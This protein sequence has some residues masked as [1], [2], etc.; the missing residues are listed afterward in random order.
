[1]YIHL[2][3]INFASTLFDSNDISTIRGGSM[4]NDLL[5]QALSNKLSAE[6][7]Q[8]GGSKLLARLADSE[9]PRVEAQLQEV[10]S[11]PDFKHLSVTWGFGETPQD[12]KSESQWRAAQL[13]SVPPVDNTAASA[14]CPLDRTRAAT[15]DEVGPDGTHRKVSS[16][17]AARREIAR[18]KRPGLFDAAEFGPARSLADIAVLP[19]HKCSVPPVVR[20]KIAVICA[21]G[22]GGSALGASLG[23]AQMSQ[24]MTAFRQRLAAAL[25]SWAVEQGLVYGAEGDMRARMDVFF[26]GGD[27]MRFVV[28]AH[29]A[30]SFVNVL[31]SVAESETE[32]GGV[33]PVPAFP[34]R[35]GVVIAQQK[36]PVRQLNALSESLEA[37]A[38][39]GPVKGQ[40]A[41][42][43]AALE[44]AS[45]PF[46][47]IRDYWSE[48]YG[49]GHQAGLE[50]FSKKELSDFESLCGEI[51]YG[52]ED[53]A[54][55]RPFL[56]ITQVNRILQEL[57]G[58]RRPLMP[59]GAS[60]SSKANELL[61]AYFERVHEDTA[62]GFEALRGLDDRRG[63][64]LLLAQIAQFKPYFDASHPKEDI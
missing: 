2:E 51:T 38:R 59:D 27:D 13:W 17:V 63:L 14:A 56:S 31:L 39:L 12:A 23:D 7:V 11:G 10:L 46:E 9:K 36:V 30:L 44:S 42:C 47:N 48:L 32:F 57:G 50:V 34:H 62:L 21:D 37:M 52:N 8:S 1:M 53:D 16:S 15:T 6:V 3:G 49:P 58:P 43:I 28:P 33:A 55:E 61:K 54:E 29:A 24:F 40:S 20:N 22:I 25:C 19:E 60:R 26:W 41:V 45:P 64:P 4:L 18:I 35:I 5:P